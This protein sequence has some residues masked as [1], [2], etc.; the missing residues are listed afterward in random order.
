MQNSIIL[1]NVTLADLGI[2]FEEAATKLIQKFLP[3]ESPKDDDLID[4]KEVAKILGVSVVTV[5]K[6][7]AAGKIPF[8][9]SPHG[10]RIYFRKSEI[11]QSLKKIER[12]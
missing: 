9:R 1:E 11:L 5:H 12:R 8:F 4:I 3:K 7:K 2:V 10:R 6:I